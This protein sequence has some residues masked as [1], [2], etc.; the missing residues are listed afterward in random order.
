MSGCPV[1][2]HWAVAMFYHTA[3]F[4]LTILTPLAMITMVFEQDSTINQPDFLGE[5]FVMV[6]H[7]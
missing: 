5:L 7:V 4:I 6:R 1:V 2:L 3:V